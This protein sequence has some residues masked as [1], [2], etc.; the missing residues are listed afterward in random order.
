MASGG[1]SITALF[2]AGYIP[3]ILTGIGIMIT[4][5]TMLIYKKNGAKLKRMAETKNGFSTL[6]DNLNPWI[7][8]KKAEI[9]TEKQKN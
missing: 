1:V 8:M 2:L 7:Q 3:G 5:I 6:R 9:N 4:A